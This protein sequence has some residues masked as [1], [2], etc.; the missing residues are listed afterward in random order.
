MPKKRLNCFLLAGGSRLSMASAFFGWG[1]LKLITGCLWTWIDVSFKTL[2]VILNWLAW[3]DQLFPT[4]PLH[5][6]MQ[7]HFDC[8]ELESALSACL[9]HVI[10]SWTPLTGLQKTLDSDACGSFVFSMLAM[11]SL[12]NALEATCFMGYR[13]S[14]GHRLI[15]W[16]VVAVFF[17]K[18]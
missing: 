18:C 1:V 15:W 17:K 4:I 5:L 7:H 11:S 16:C 3:L 13:R 9:V 6:M 14:A 12:L 10:C 8:W 2:L